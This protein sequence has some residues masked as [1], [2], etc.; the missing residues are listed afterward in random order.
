[1]GLLSNV[2][3]SQNFKD[4]SQQVE[5]ASIYIDMVAIEGG[6]FIMG[7]NLGKAEEKPAHKVSVSDFWIG[8]YEI[9]WEQYDAFIYANLMPHN[10]KTIPN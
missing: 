1:M 10:F 5:S 8:K 6:H 9:T 7:N 4:Y 2:T 3:L